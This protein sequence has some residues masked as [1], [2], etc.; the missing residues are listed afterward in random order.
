MGREKYAQRP[1]AVQSAGS[2]NVDIPTGGTLISNPA[3]PRSARQ[4]TK[5][6]AGVIRE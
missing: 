2:E 6:A 1:C 4:D 5:L 3:A